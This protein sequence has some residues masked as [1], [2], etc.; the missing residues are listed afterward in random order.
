MRHNPVK[1]KINKGEPAF[2]VWLAF[3]SPAR[4]EFFG[5]LG[6]EFVIIDGE[7]MP[8]SPATCLELVRACE[9]VG[10]VPIVRPPNHESSTIL[11]FLET[12]ALGIYVPH[13]QTAQDAEAV[14]QAVKYAP[15]GNRSAGSSE[16]PANYG[17]TQ[18]PEDYYAAANDETMVILLVED[19]VG[20]SNLDEIV[21]VPGI[22]VVAIGPGDLSLSMGR[23]KSRA[24]PEVMKAVR[25]AEARIADAGLPF[26]CEPRNA[27]E[28][29]EAIERGAR[30]VP[31]FEGMMMAQLFG[32]VLDDL[33]SSGL[34]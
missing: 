26:D 10:V 30:L 28:A 17:L 14:V 13:V 27:D 5:H 25:N 6:F 20:V 32:G 23:L 12:G 16:R 22:D 8:I 34:R 19:T 11:P 31:F 3:P 18:P 4:V 29:R 7:H 33:A 1:E 2:G 21:K 15:M 9:L 24:D